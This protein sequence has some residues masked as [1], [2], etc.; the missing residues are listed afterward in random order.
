MPFKQFVDGE[1]LTDEDVDTYFIQQV[2]KIKSADQ[3]VTSSTVVVADT[4]LFLPV[5]A[6]TQYWL[7]IFLLVDVIQAAD[8]KMSWT[9]PAGSAMHWSHGG[10]ALTAADS[11]DRISRTYLTLASTG[12]PGGGYAAASNITVVVGEGRLSTAG[13]A[14]NLQLFWAQNTSSATGSIM[15]ANS[16]IILQRLT[17]M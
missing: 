6:N 13:T 7:E 14:G 10:L 15:K 17:G 4:H 8:L 2:H 11:A 9:A 16:C 12:T 1:V 3:A 5:L